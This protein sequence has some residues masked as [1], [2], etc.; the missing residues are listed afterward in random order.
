MPYK[1]PAERSRNRGASNRASASLALLTDNVLTPRKVVLSAHTA[2]ENE[3]VKISLHFT[4]II[5]KGTFGQIEKAT[6]TVVNENKES[7]S[8]EAEKSTKPGEAS[9]LQVAVKRVLQDPRYKNRELGIMQK[10]G[11][12]PNIVRFYY[13]YYSSTSLSGKNSSS[14]NQ[15]SDSN[16]QLFLHLILE[17]FPGSLCD[18]IYHYSQ[19]GSSPIPV[20]TVKLF[21]YQ[22]LK[23]LA[24]LHS[25]RICHRDIKSSNLLVS[26]ATCVLK[27]CDFGSAK[28]M[29]PGTP[30]V[31]YISSR[32]YRAPELLFG[33]QS[34]T[35]AIDTWSAGC[36][37]A[38]MLRQSCLFTGT[39]S[40]DQLVKVIRVLGTPSAD[41]IASMNPVYET[42]CFP[43]VR[44][45]PVKLFFPH[46]TPAD[47]LSLMSQMLVYNPSKRILPKEALSHACFDNLRQM[48]SSTEASSNSKVSVPE[49]MFEPNPPSPSNISWLAEA[50]QSKKG[51]ANATKSKGSAPE[52]MFDP[53][54]P[55]PTD[56]S[57]LAEAGMSKKSEAN[58]SK[59]KKG[60]EP[61]EAAVT[62][63]D[64][65]AASN[66]SEAS[67]AAKL[68]ELS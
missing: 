20:L 23:A 19:Q 31:S 18:L 4:E 44:S 11:N 43:D 42:Y 61:T 10:L 68:T 6:L 5:G 28:E 13:Y 26:E 59:S 21:T 45:C 34:Y 14:N 50:G 62:D 29:T 12:H 3:S 8:A 53:N 67:E 64:S 32:Y 49:G 37:L 60:A 36:V 1:H 17:C 55:A 41:D 35:C 46:A 56:I 2:H 40:V 51:E 58:A 9:P 33:A 16:I 48:Q 63:L 24:Y 54:L 66:K 39:D 25:H 30:N 57:W 7:G 52:G 65:V 38:E 27:V 15:N 47:L 22:M